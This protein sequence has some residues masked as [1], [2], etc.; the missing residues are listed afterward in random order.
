[1]EN[2]AQNPASSL[3]NK[4]YYGFAGFLVLV[5]FIL[6]LTVYWN[7]QGQVREAAKERLRDIAAI[8][9]IQVDAT[10]HNA[11]KV[12]DDEG[13]PTYLKLRRDLQRIRDTTTDIRYI[14]T[15]R[16]GPRD[17][18]VFVLDAETIPEEIA[19]LGDLYDDASELLR[20]KFRS[21]DQ[22]IVEDD[23]YTDKWGTWLTGYAPFYTQDG[24]RAGVV[25]IDIAA[26]HV[27]ERERLFFLNSL[28]VLA[29]AMLVILFLAWLIG[30]RLSGIA[31]KAT[32]A[33]RE[34]EVRFRDIVRASG[35]WFWEV[36][37]E[38]RF[39]TVS[40]S[41][42]S[43][44][45]YT[46]AEMLEK[47]IFH[48]MPPEEARRLGPLFPTMIEEAKPF[49]DLDNICVRKDG[50]TRYVQTSGM[51]IFDADGKLLGY[52]G[53]DRDISKRKRAENELRQAASVFKYANEGI[54]ITDPSG[55]ILDVNDTFTRIT[56]FDRKEAVGQN[57]SILKSGRQD[58]LFYNALWRD[59]LEKGYWNGEIWNR[60]KDGEIFAEMLTISVVKD[61]QGNVQHYVGL[62]SDITA[63]KQHERRLEHVAHYDALTD[64]PNRTLLADRLYQAV[65]QAQRRKQSLG[66]V[67]LDLDGF[68]GIN[69][70]HGHEV[71][72][73]FL[74]AL[75]QRIQQTLRESD[76]IARLGGDEFVAILID[77][78][79]TKDSVP[80]LERLLSAASQ[81]VYVDDLVLQVSASIGVTFYPQPEPIEADQLLRQAD[82]AMYQAKL[83]GK[84]RYH[85]FDAEQDRSVKGLHETLDRIGSAL[86]EREFMLLYQPRVNM[87]TGQCVGA[88][89]LIRWQH[90][91]RGLL[92]PSVF[93]PVIEDH[94]LSV[95]LGEWVLNTA[96]TQ[97]EAWHANGLD[98]S[99]SVNIG[100]RQ[101]QQSDFAERLRKLL[102]EHPSIDPSQVVLEILETSALEDV[103]KVSHV[104]HA[105][106]K[107]GVRFAL[108]DFGT[109]YSSLTYLKRLPVDQIKIDRSFVRDMLEDSEDLGIIEG[110]LGLATVFH[111][112]V[113]AEGVENAE[114]GDMLLQ[115]GCQLAQ[116]YG[117]ARPITA[118]E[119]SEWIA[120]WQPYPTWTH[121]HPIIHDDLPLLFAGVEHRA[122][123]RAIEEHLDGKRI[124]PPPLDEHQCRFGQWLTGVGQARHGTNAT[125]KTVDRLHQEVHTL[126]AELLKRKAE[127]GSTA[128][129]AGLSELHKLRDT[130]IEQLKRLQHE[131]HRGA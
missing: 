48:F 9:A 12:P 109:G 39:T 3:G 51:P 82:Q 100:A 70:T 57:P 115:L 65:L 20:E 87:H 120:T 110:V 2:Q 45:G 63:L 122:W 30:R 127:D 114:H 104:I 58:K 81:T 10:A 74:I 17:E 8:T 36:D 15:M 116:G 5:S 117:I 131:N 16:Q 29:V 69:D 40:D 62:F 121:Q 72:D 76:T 112:E 128:A 41:V 13:N 14:Y 97:V 73:Q 4:I 54:M 93:L 53:L 98:I 123:V 94:P 28:R 56:E 11:L 118:N 108:D 42:E 22:P 99:V 18:I 83:A 130:L 75:A 78:A 50:T 35:D 68:K 31:I 79:E 24:Q 88:E 101:L 96:L 77:L 84:N 95:E 91:E 49:R 32:Q 59:L 102:I 103:A 90:P 61:A 92:P 64:L 80:M 25:G 38:G 107:L 67:Y 129:K 44:L 23:F 124:T 113:V 105:C 106:H 126:T 111:R 34:S 47:S 26:A 86:A 66:V 33:L 55:V 60:R 27:M 71:G 37:T 19:H 21:L 85:F 89:A 7:Y 125:F 52:R 6:A 119:L 43:L 46:P 1:M